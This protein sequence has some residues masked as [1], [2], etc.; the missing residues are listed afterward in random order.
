MNFSP[1]LDP[2]CETIFLLISVAPMIF[3]PNQKIEAAIGEDVT[4]ECITEATPKATSY[5]YFKRNGYIW[6]SDRNGTM[7]SDRFKT[8]EHRHS[9]YKVDLKLHITNIQRGDFGN[10]DRVTPCNS[11]LKQM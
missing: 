9:N 7:Y 5:W 2:S 6:Y 10:S 4:L 1:L 3:V 8:H 11:I